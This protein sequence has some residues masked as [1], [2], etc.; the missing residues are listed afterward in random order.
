[1]QEFNLARGP[2]RWVINPVKGL[3]P[4]T[5]LFQG[6]MGLW[7]GCSDLEGFSFRT[8]DFLPNTEARA[9]AAEKNHVSSKWEICET[10]EAAQ[11]VAGWPQRWRWLPKNWKMKDLIQWYNQL[12][13][14]VQGTHWGWSAAQDEVVGMRSAAPSPLKMGGLLFQSQLLPQVKL[15]MY[16]SVLFMSVMEY[17]IDLQIGAGSAVL[18]A[19]CG[20]ERAEPEGEALCFPDLWVADS[21]SQWW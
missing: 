6:W 4:P 13:T 3:L 19:C 16:L 8:Q 20:E 17:K 1:M 11:W 12:S 2:V 14:R 21:S 9:A 5:P 18:P 10:K 15:L 7:M